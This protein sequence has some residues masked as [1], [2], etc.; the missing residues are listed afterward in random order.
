MPLVPGEAE[1][2][3]ADEYR[4][5]GDLTD[6]ELEA[7]F[8]RES[9]RFVLE[10]NREG[11]DAIC[12]AFRR[13]GYIVEPSRFPQRRV[14]W[15]NEQRSLLIESFILNVPVPPLYLL[16]VRPNTFDVIDGQQ[17]I[18]TILDFF[19][20]ALVLSG[21][22]L[23]PELNGLRYDTLPYMIQ[24]RIERRNLEYIIVVPTVS[25]DGE[26]MKNL[27]RNMFVRLNAG[28]SI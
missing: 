11:L 7:R 19:A 27:I 18:R 25:L 5:N 9:Q 15:S 28:G 13:P 6:A 21:L 17:R 20:G 14:G 8:Q 4:P 12:G 2:W 3:K 16:E 24:R 1:M 10:V 26:E 23:C 22:K